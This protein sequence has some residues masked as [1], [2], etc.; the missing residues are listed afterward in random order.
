MKVNDIPYQTAP[1]IFC[2]RGQ[3]LGETLTWFGDPHD[4][5]CMSSESDQSATCKWNEGVRWGPSI[6]W[7]V[8]MEKPMGEN[9]THTPNLRNPIC[10]FHFILMILR[11]SHLW[12][13]LGGSGLE[14]VTQIAPVRDWP[15]YGGVQFHFQMPMGNL[16]DGVKM[17]QTSFVMFSYSNWRQFLWN[18]YGICSIRLKLLVGSINARPSWSDFMAKEPRFC[19]IET[20]ETSDTPNVTGPLHDSTCRSHFSSSQ[21]V[22]QTQRSGGQML[23][24]AP[25]QA[26]EDALTSLVESGI[27]CNNVSIQQ[28]TVELFADLFK[29][30][31]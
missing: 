29:F 22:V 6:L 26:L 20:S 23:M 2:L 7:D 31:V 12:I 13:Y 17:V 5:P 30:E 25:W 16:F 9:G 11:V 19:P 1:S 21:M 4:P 27:G 10:C 8:L 3:Y 28:H 14:V 18:F 24:K 15:T